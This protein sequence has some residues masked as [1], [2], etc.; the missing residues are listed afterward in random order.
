MYAFI[1]EIISNKIHFFNIKSE[2][3]RSIEIGVTITKNTLL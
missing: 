2:D 1:V 3:V